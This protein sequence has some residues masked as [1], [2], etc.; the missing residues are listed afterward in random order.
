MDIAITGSS[1]LIG[2]EL[3]RQLSARGDRW[4]RVV[5]RAPASSDEIRWDPAAGTIDAAG[6]EGVDAVVNLAGENIAARR[7]SDAQKA[8]IVDSRVKGTTLLA[9]TLASAQKPPLALVSGSAI[10]FYG[11]RGD[12]ALD[13]RSPRGS[14]FLSDLVHQWEGA[15]HLAQEAGIRVAF[16]RTGLVLSK[17]E[18]ALVP[19]LRLFRLG[20]GGRLGP[21][22]QWWSW[23]TLEDEVRAIVH[24]IDHDITGPANLVSPEPVTNAAFTKA[25]ASALHRPAFL[26]VPSFGPK[27]VM[28]SE[29]ADELIFASQRIA[30]M[31]LVDSGFIFSHHELSE[32][33]DSVLHPGGHH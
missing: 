26:P 17:E 23:I 30:P 6:L 29:L 4:V 25:L 11:S 13:E 20:L 21:G 9:S 18:G 27:L 31:V 8:R 22:T 16:A 19:L 32:A 3:V 24:L 14:G 2:S 33:L 12:E 5:R 1:G 7:W 15:A 10:G 28:G